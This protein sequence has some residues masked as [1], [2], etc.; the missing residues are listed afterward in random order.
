[1]PIGAREKGCPWLYIYIKYCHDHLLILYLFYIYF[2]FIL[3]YI[4]FIFISILYLF[5]IY[6]IFISILYLFYI[7]IVLYSI[8]YL[9]CF[10]FYYFY[11][12]KIITN[13]NLILLK[14]PIKI[15]NDIIIILDK[16]NQ[17]FNNKYKII[18]L[19]NQ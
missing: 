1:M 4:Y 8:L 3:F 6:F 14:W 10:I 7:Y 11:M 18:I 16:F 19:N 5:Y 15:S 9:Y 12:A 13:I 17:I 2:I